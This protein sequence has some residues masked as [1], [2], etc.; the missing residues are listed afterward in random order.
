M[1]RLRT[2][3]LVAG[4][5]VFLIAFGLETGR[6]LVPP[7]PPDVCAV[8]PECEV[9]TKPCHIPCDET[10]ANSTPRP[11]PRCIQLDQNLCAEWKKRQNRHFN[12]YEA[13]ESNEARE[14]GRLPGLGIPR[15]ALLDGVLLVTLALIGATLVVPERFMAIGAAVTTLIA[16]FSIT[17]GSISSIV[18]ALS[19]LF[20][21]IGLFLS[22]PFGTMAYLAKW[23]IFET[24]EAANILAPA[25]GLKIAL[26]VLLVLAQQRFLGNKGLMLLIGTSILATFLLSFLHSFPPG[27]LVSITDAA[28]AVIVGILALIWA[29]MML[30]GAIVA[31]IRMVF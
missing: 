7:D 16:G 31:I 5:V 22:A 18:S 9:A 21:M 1:E 4:L 12:I 28:G 17:L 20:V 6:A 15:L 25:M 14:P 23:G 29:L 11:L 30:I 27:I 2:P 13:L 3:F 19:Q 26:V 10:F 24:G 8:P